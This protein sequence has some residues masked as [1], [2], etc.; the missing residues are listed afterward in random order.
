MEFKVKRDFLLVFLINIVLAFILALA[1]YFSYNTAVLVIFL[2]LAIGGIALFNTSVIFASCKIDNEELI[3]KTGIFKYTIKLNT[4][5]KITPSKNAYGSL[6]LSFDRL[7]ILT[8]SEGKQKVYYISVVDNEK[9]LSV[10]TPNKKAEEPKQEVAETKT[11]EVKS[12]AKKTT[13]TKK[14]TTSTAK[15][16]T[17]KSNSTKKSTTKKAPAK[18][19]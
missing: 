4:I 8:V 7:R 13:T 18:K 19:E 6:S 17:A 5:A 2:I 10:L 15:K 11:E 12:P 14:K 3:F 9:L 16:T 1:L